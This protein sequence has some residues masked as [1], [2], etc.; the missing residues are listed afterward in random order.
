MGGVKTR[1][2]RKT[3]SIKKMILRA[4]LFEYCTRCS[5]ALVNEYVPV[6]YVF[7]LA[8]LDSSDVVIE[9]E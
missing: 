4:I 7:D 1:E 6:E 5:Q 2:K 9:L 3:R 8:S